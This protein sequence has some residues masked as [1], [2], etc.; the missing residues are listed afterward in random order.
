MILGAGFIGSESA[1]ALKMEYKDKLQVHLV[2]MLENPLERVLGSHL[3]ARMG[4]EH[5]D[6]G[7]VLHMK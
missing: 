5:T 1:S 2:D 4:K 7:V 3:G 6:N